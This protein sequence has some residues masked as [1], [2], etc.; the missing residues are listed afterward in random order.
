[1]RLLNELRVAPISASAPQGA[2]HKDE[3][4]QHN[5]NERE[6]PPK[7]AS[8]PIQGAPADSDRGAGGRILTAHGV[9][10]VG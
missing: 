8:T 10:P 6:R 1:M 7:A 5:D 3:I 2:R 9:Y 4:E